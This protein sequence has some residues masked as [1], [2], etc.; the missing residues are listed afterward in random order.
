MHKV[1]RKLH[2]WSMLLLGLQFII[3]SVTGAYMVLVDI[4]YIHGNSLVN[5]QHKPIIAKDIS[6]SI[7]QL[8]QDFPYASDISMANLLNQPVYRFTHQDTSMMISAINGKV[9]SPLSKQDAIELAQQQYTGDGSVLNALWI[10]EN[11]PFELSPRHLPVWR[12][13][14]DDFAAPAL[15]ISATSGLVV[16]KRHDFWRIFDWMFRFHIMDYSSGEDIDNQ[17][18]FWVALFSLLSVSSG[19]ILIYYSVIKPYTKKR[20]RIINK[21]RAV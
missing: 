13:N 19:G 11:P 15:Y 6:Y 7:A 8:Q 5:N 18:L 16:T 21:A 14:F 2:R 12:V 1:A 3:W 4:N 20:Q 10:T 9:L 17:L